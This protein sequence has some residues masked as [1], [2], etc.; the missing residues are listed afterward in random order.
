MFMV[1][2]NRAPTISN[3]RGKVTVLPFLTL[4]MYHVIHVIIPT[5]LFPAWFR[6]QLYHGQA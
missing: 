2:L 1:T 5:L 3:V 6:E 4:D